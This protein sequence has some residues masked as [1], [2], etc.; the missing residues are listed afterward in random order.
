VQLS[1]RLRRTRVVQLH[2]VTLQDPQLLRTPARAPEGHLA[3]LAPTKIGISAE[4]IA[5]SHDAGARR[6]LA[7][8]LELIG[9]IE[10]ARRSRA[11]VIVQLP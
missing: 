7:E 2:D 9:D 11:D 5:A 8:Q 6:V 3:V 1:R 4:L 10:R